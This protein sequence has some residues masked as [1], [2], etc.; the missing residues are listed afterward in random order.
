[1]N[2]PRCG[3]TMQEKIKSVVSTDKE[4][5]KT[6]DQTQSMWFCR[7]CKTCIKNK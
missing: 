6:A 5:I 1:M 4:G 3:S 2:C 7:D